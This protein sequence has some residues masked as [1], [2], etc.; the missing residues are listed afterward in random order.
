M[1]DIK[2]FLKRDNFS[3]LVGIE[4]LEVKP[5]YART[6][7]EIKPHHLNGFRAVHGGVIFTLADLACAAASNAEGQLTVLVSASIH[8]IKSGKGGTLF[9]EA[10]KICSN[11]KLSSFEIT[12]SDDKAEIIASFQ[13]L[14]Y[15][16][17]STLEEVI[18][19][20]PD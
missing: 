15:H 16:K 7:L 9:A 8:Y 17:K 5:G 14:A 4:L 1:E 13:G 10:K 12:I 6:K 3:N 20:H 11:A 18:R 19:L 2:S